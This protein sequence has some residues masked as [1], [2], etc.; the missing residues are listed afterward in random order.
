MTLSKSEHAIFGKTKKQDVGMVQLVLI[1]QAKIKELMRKSPELAQRDAAGMLAAH[2]YL[3]LMKD[4]TNQKAI[5][6]LIGPI[7]KKSTVQYFQRAS[8][9]IEGM[10]PDPEWEVPVA[11]IAWPLDD[12]STASSR[13]VV[14]S[15][16]GRELKPLGSFLDDLQKGNSSVAVMSEGRSQ[17]GSQQWLGTV[18]SN[19]SMVF[20]EQCQDSTWASP[21]RN[22][23]QPVAPATAYRL[24][25]QQQKLSMDKP[26]FSEE[27]LPEGRQPKQKKKWWQFWK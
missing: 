24:P 23:G 11:L 27:S 8:E 7:L 22:C 14:C 6:Q 17:L 21:C 4:V 1:R 3:N 25:Q 5:E 12:K 20:C 15:R 26:P 2:L 9:I 10:E 13:V 18:C 16:C 19:C